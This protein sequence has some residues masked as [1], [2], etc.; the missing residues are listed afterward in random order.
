MIVFVK[1]LEVE[2]SNAVPFKRMRYPVEN[3]EVF[4]QRVRMRRE[5]IMG[6][7]QCSYDVA[8]EITDLEFAHLMA[9]TKEMVSED[10]PGNSRSILARYD[11]TDENFIRQSIQFFQNSDSALVQEIP[12]KTFQKFRYGS[13]VNLDLLRRSERPDYKDFWTINTNRLTN[14][15]SQLNL[16]GCY[17]PEEEFFEQ[18]K[19][20]SMLK[21]AHEFGI[22]ANVQVETFDFLQ[23]AVRQARPPDGNNSNIVSSGDELVMKSDV[24]S[25]THGAG[26]TLKIRLK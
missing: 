24:A 6:H 9:T 18:Q 1:G 10:D 19:E 26:T 17:S 20:K 22:M 15:A 3:G 21:C 16:K 4:Q 25:T 11:V 7:L 5:Q 12:M 8:E 2:D 14:I 13:G 23:K